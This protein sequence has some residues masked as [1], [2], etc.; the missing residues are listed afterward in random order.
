MTDNSF[1]S[2]AVSTKGGVVSI[3]TVGSGQAMDSSAAVAAYQTAQSGAVPLGILMQ[4]VVNEDLTDKSQNFYKTTVQLGGKLTYA[5]QGI[6]E[7][8]MIASNITV[9]AKDIAYLAGSG[10]LTNVNSGVINTP[11][12][13]KFLSTKDEDGY[14]K[15][16]IEL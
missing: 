16:K 10:M 12:V 2:N 8:N 1:F 13:G 14:A 9:A 6:V 3:V 4:D 7:T 5:Y 15:L 11:K